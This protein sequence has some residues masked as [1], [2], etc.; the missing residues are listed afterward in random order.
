MIYCIYINHGKEFIMQK[1]GAI[2]DKD[3]IIGFL[4][5]D[6]PDYLGR[7]YN[8]MVDWTDDQIEQCHDQVQHLFPLHEESKMAV[9][10][11][12]ISREITDATKNDVKIQKNMLAATIRFEKFLSVGEYFSASDTAKWCKNGNHNLLRITRIIRSL[13][14]FGFSEAAR[15]FH[16]HV[17]EPTYYHKINSK[18]L[19]YWQ[20]AMFDDVWAPLQENTPKEA[21]KTN[22]IV[23]LKQQHFM[24]QLIAHCILAGGKMFSIEE[25]KNMPVEK[26][27]DIVF[28]N[29]MQLDVN[30]EKD[31]IVNLGS[32]K[33]PDYREL[34]ST[35]KVRFPC[36]S[37]D[38][39]ESYSQSQREFIMQTLSKAQRESI[40][41][42]N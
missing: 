18:T 6:T 27:L 34:K 33:I 13:R 22:A 37:D 21:K 2:T 12:V 16:S 28:C 42:C 15:S 35:A 10:Y 38:E 29:H 17:I 23:Q 8:Q 40:E 20:K 5:G 19:Q 24:E 30:F 14:L 31:C 41:S 4:R 1:Q 25:I 9:C 32:C 39:W 3:Y 7:Y 26:L 11:P 36:I